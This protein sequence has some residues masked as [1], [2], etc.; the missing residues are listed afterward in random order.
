VGLSEGR[1]KE[2]VVNTFPHVTI[3]FECKCNMWKWHIA[4]ISHKSGAKCQA[5][6][7]GLNIKCI[8]KIAK[9]RVEPQLPHT[10]GERKITGVSGRWWWTSDSVGMTLNYV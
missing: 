8:A 6:Q 9:G 2:A 3:A 4:K 10:A 1:S 5:Q 7:K